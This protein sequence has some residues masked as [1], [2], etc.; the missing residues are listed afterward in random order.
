MEAEAEKAYEA[1]SATRAVGEASEAEPERLLAN[2]Y[3]NSEELEK[4]YLN[5]QS[6]H[7]STFGGF[8]GAPDGDYEYAAND[9]TNFTLDPDSDLTKSFNELARN[10]N[11]SQ[12]CYK[13]CIDMFA[14]AQQ[15]SSKSAS[16]ESIK[17][18]ESLHKQYIKDLGGNEDAVIVQTEELIGKLGRIQALSDDHITAL[19]G[20]MKNSQAFNAL[21]I[22][23]N[24][25][26]YSS[27][28]QSASS[29]TLSGADLKAKLKDKGNMS[30]KE[31][32][33]LRK[34]YAEAYPGMRER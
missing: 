23:M 25:Q 2:K 4:G 1:P 7:D 32:E 16:D 13:N 24:E 30:A 12:E 15:S 19:I 8:T 20:E 21:K 33:N 28:P 26:D 18:E 34:S 27:V 5:L 9:E 31:R 17:H 22:I 3:K 11:M 29:P 14:K 10:S 6:K